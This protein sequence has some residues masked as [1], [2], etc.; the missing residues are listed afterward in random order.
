MEII[1]SL[2]R[3]KDITEFSGYKTCAQA[4]Y[5]FEVKAYD[6][7]DMLHRIYAYAKKNS[8]PFLILG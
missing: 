5:Y 6:D 1:D 8:L 3:N 2:E 4:E 7:I